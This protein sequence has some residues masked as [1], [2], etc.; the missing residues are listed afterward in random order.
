MDGATTSSSSALVAAPRSPAAAQPGYVNY[1]GSRLRAWIAAIYFPLVMSTC[2]FGAYYLH[3]RGLPLELIPLVTGP[4]AALFA[5][6][7]ETFQPLVLRTPAWREDVAVDTVFAFGFGFLLMLAEK[8]ISV[9][10]WYALL[11]LGLSVSEETGGGLWPTTWPLVAQFG[12][13]AVVAELGVYWAH[14]ILHATELGWRFHSVHH[15]PQIVYWWNSPRH[16]IVDSVFVAIPTVTLL[17]IAGVPRDVMAFFGAFAIAQSYF[18]HSNIW[19]SFGPL[20][21]VLST[22]VLHRWHHSKDRV[23]ANSNYGTIVM[24]WDQLFGTFNFPKDRVQPPEDI[25]VSYANYP[26]TFLGQVLIP[27]RW[28]TLREARADDPDPR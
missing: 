4:Y 20:A 6:L 24:I 26:R 17:M 18:Q 9:V 12:L 14:R 27:F 1:A 7:G 11:K 16:H 22:N 5:F 8:G 23:D 25:G 19:L 21:Y 10:V 13:A 3:T 28:S 15:S 2:M